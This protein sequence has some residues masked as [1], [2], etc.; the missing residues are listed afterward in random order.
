MPEPISTT[1]AAAASAAQTTA[2]ATAAGAGAGAGAATTEAAKVEILRK[3]AFSML[4][5]SETTVLNQSELVDEFATPIYTGLS[6]ANAK[7]ASTPGTPSVATPQDNS[8]PSAATPQDN[9]ALSNDKNAS[10]NDNSP[11]RCFDPRIIDPRIIICDGPNQ[12]KFP[13][14]YPECDSGPIGKPL[15]S[16]MPEIKQ[17]IN[18]HYKAPTIEDQLKSG[19]NEIVIE[20]N[21]V[22]GQVIKGDSKSTAIVVIEERVVDKKYLEYGHLSD[23][24]SEIR[25]GN[26]PSIKQVYL[27]LVDLT[28]LA[29]FKLLRPYLMKYKLEDAQVRLRQLSADIEKKQL[30]D[31]LPD[32][33]SHN[34]LVDRKVDKREWYKTDHV[35]EKYGHQ[36]VET[37]KQLEI[38]ALNVKE[39][40]T[41]NM[42]QIEAER[43]IQN[44]TD[45]AKMFGGSEG[46]ARLETM[47]PPEQI[48]S[49]GKKAMVWTRENV[50]TQTSEYTQE[51]FFHRYGTDLKGFLG[52]KITESDKNV[53]VSRQTTFSEYLSESDNINL[54]NINTFEDAHSKFSTLKTSATMT[55]DSQ[56]IDRYVE[57]GEGVKFEEGWITYIPGGSI[58]NLGAKADLGA[59]LTGWDYFWAGL[60][61]ATIAVAC[62]TFGASSGATAAGKAA[63]T[64]GAKTVVKGG[65]KVVAKQ[66]A[67]AALRTTAKQSAKAVAKTG[68]KAVAK[69]TGKVALKNTGKATAKQTGKVT[70][71]NTGKAGVKSAKAQ[72]VKK[73]TTKTVARARNSYLDDVVKRSKVKDTIDVSKLKKRPWKRISP[74]KNKIMREQFA[75]SDF[76]DSLIKEWERI[77][78]RKWPTY[79]KDVYSKNG[80]LIRHA[81]DKFDAHHIQP[82]GM[83]GQNVASNLTPMHVLDHADHWGIHAYGSPYDTLNNV[84]GAI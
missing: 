65:A 51:H 84:L 73:V 80:K 2:T 13:I 57:A 64:A 18:D 82:L 21:I 63:L 29:T 56:V 10:I 61:V 66:G 71:K 3:L 34:F 78:N 44:K 83:N 30:H 33:K 4:Q 7:L 27:A 59:K 70:L 42:S 16:E 20:R 52:N 49:V 67:K 35:T 25:H 60:D 17:L 11:S 38:V 54:Q 24:M 46:I 40:C 28:D 23:V 36:D 26:I 58:V 8:T 76:K 22:D 32:K 43:I 45:L 53:S 14:P 77:N 79:E 15:P 72:V 48:A 31:T 75:N 9:I 5:T 19:A 74:E 1:A 37:V 6:A 69:Q 81:G 39:L 47:L 12:P 50:I 41:V 55:T 68:G 62:V